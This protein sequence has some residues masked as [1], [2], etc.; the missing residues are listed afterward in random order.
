MIK[1]LIRLIVKPT[2][3]RAIKKQ[4]KKHK[5]KNLKIKQEIF[6]YQLICN[7]IKLQL[8]K[9][10]ILQN[11]ENILLNKKIKEYFIVIKFQ[12]LMILQVKYNT[13]HQDDY[14]KLVLICQT[15]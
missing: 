10:N 9:D 6:M 12:V 5:I 7:K 14:L 4:F 13:L 2:I 11:K 8:E 15:L 1:L 3:E